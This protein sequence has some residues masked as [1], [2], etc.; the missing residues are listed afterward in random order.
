[1][2]R[3]KTVSPVLV[4]LS[5]SFLLSSQIEA[6]TPTAD[7]LVFRHVEARGGLEAIESIETLVFS[8]GQYTEPGYSSN[9]K[10]FMAFR[11]PYYKVVGDPRLRQSFM[12]GWDGAAWEWFEDP[13]I[14]I[15]TVGPASGAAR[16]S[17]ELDG[18]LVHYRA[19]GSAVERIDG[20]DIGGRPAYGIRVTTMDGFSRD[21]FLDRDSFLIVAERRSAPFHAYGDPITTETRYE[22][23]REVAGVLFPHRF[24]ETVIATG[25]ILTTMQWGSI[26]AN[27]ELP[28]AWFSPPQ[29]DRTE[30]QR[31]LEQLYAVRTD[32]RALLWTYEQFRRFHPQVATGSG[33]ELIGYQISKMGQ[34]EQAVTLLEANAADHPESASAAFALG[35]AYRAANDLTGARRAFEKVRS[36]DPEHDRAAAELASLTAD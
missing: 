8:A 19:K 14:V 31:F 25:E 32:S 23:Y 30:L 16:R 10:A 28:R 21:Y 5:G 36:L 3:M 18:P 7:D 24:T 6:E 26:E 34:T 1:M 33:V 13:G 29:F 2:A 35:R 20:A 15:R 27:L 17:S 22:D 12:E 4:F 11:R 9:G